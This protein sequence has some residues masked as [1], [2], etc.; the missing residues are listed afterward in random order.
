MAKIGTQLD[1]RYVATESRCR[2]TSKPTSSGHSRLNCWPERSSR[3]ERMG[4][5]HTAR[6]LISSNNWL[7]TTFRVDDLRSSV[8]HN[9]FRAGSRKESILFLQNSCISLFMFPPK[10]DTAKDIRDLKSWILSVSL[11][12]S[13]A[14]S[15]AETIEWIIYFH[16]F[17]V[18]S[19]FFLFTCPI[20]FQTKIS[21]KTLCAE[22][23]ATQ[24]THK[25]TRKMSLELSR[26]CIFGGNDE[27][28][29]DL[30]DVVLEEIIW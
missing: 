7:N 16:F 21:N 27:Q 12:K 8:F 24:H 25:I 17:I 6:T 3:L 30:D 15:L 22:S 19:P 26:L 11:C 1:L 9:A 5:M 4:G 13:L 18:L 23:R 20:F 28:I 14:V 10:G 29:L 2:P